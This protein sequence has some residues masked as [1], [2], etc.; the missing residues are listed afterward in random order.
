MGRFSAFDIIG[1]RMIGPSSSHT[2]GAARLSGLARKIA[3]TD[4]ASAEITLYGSFAETGK[5]HGTDKALCAGLLGIASDDNRL[6]FSI[7]LAEEAGIDIRFIYSDDE[8]AHP[9]HVR[10]KITAS[11]GAVTTVEGN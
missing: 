6:R 4:V 9:N 11:D 5:G 7:L 1:P 2:A 10:I 3:G 8:A